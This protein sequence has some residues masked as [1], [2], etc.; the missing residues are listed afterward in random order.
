MSAVCL[1]ARSIS[2]AYESGLIFKRRRSILED[3]SLELKSGET[4]GLVG[5]SGSGKSTLGRIIAGL[6]RPTGGDVLFHGK[7]IYEM[8]GAEFSKFRRSVQTLFQDPE[9]SLNPRKSIERSMHDVLRLIGLPMRDW[10]RRTSEML[11]MVG[12]TEEILCRRPDQLSG[13]Q[14]QR[15][16]LGRVLLLEPE[17]IVLDEPTSALDISVQAQ[18]LHMLK[19]LQRDLSTGYLLIS[20]DMDV[21]KFMADRAGCLEQGRVIPLDGKSIALCS[22]IR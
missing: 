8:N 13:G 15:A 22:E 16:A 12:L 7:S 3:V 9:G 20:H 1:N 4:F 2:K 5:D 17:V 18:M 6:E 21:V 14:N 11:Q 19:D 10:R